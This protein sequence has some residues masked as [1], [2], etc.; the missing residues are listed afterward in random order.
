MKKKG[1][2][3]LSS[4]KLIGATLGAIGF[5]LTAFDFRIVGAV[6]IGFGGV[7]LAIGN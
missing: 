5:Y 4:V 1:K 6:F 2:I 3:N 7:L